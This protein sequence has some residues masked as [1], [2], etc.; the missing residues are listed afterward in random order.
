[1]SISSWNFTG[2]NLV[3]AGDNLPVLEQLPDE[4]F[5]LIYI[6]P[7]FNTGKVQSRQSLKTVR[8]DAPVAGSRVGFQGQTY[9]TVRGK[10]TA[11]NDSFSDYW[12]FLEPRLEQAW[13]LLAPTGT[14][15]LHLDYREVHY[16]KV[17]LDALF[18][19]DCFLNEI[20]WAYDYGG[21]SKR[22]WPAKHD[23]ILVYVK[24]Q[25]QYYFDSDSVDR[26]PYM[27][28]GLV[29][30]EKAARGKLPTDVWWHTIVS[31]TGKE[32]TGYATQKPEGILR[33]IVQASSRPGDWVLD[34]FAGSGTTGA[35]AG[36]LERR[37]VL[38]DENPEA[39]EIMRSRLNR[40]NISVE[41]LSE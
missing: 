2:S 26:E 5:Q 6:D 17:L 8:S 22:K 24:D 19:R 33:R 12:G 39:I 29:T 18:G 41:Y 37:F 34:F 32:K 10:V 36:T 9:E 31:P 38:I 25:K 4:S 21:R 27:A 40:A 20:I 30:P 3:V 1:M 16:A 28:P 7:P 14:L 35:V 23:N 15:Y 13:R 11:Y